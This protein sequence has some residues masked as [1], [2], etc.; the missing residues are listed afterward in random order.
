MCSPSTPP[1]RWTVRA[2][3]LWLGKS[4]GVA[5]SHVSRSKT[6][7]E[8]AIHHESTKQKPGE[9]AKSGKNYEKRTFLQTDLTGHR[10]AEGN[11]VEEAVPRCLSVESGGVGMRCSESFPDDLMFSTCK[12]WI[13][14]SLCWSILNY[15]DL[16]C[17]LIVLL[18]LLECPEN[19]VQCC[20]LQT[21]HA[22]QNVFLSKSLYCVFFVLSKDLFYRPL[23]SP[24]H[25][26]KVCTDLPSVTAASW[27]AWGQRQGHQLQQCHQ[28]MPGD[29]SKVPISIEKWREQRHCSKTGLRTRYCR[30]RSTIM[31]CLLQPVGFLFERMD[32]EGSKIERDCYFQAA[33]CN[34]TLRRVPAGLTP[35][36]C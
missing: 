29:S 9:L 26:P 36:S 18:C 25:W 14:V 10:L 28:R 34:T 20:H 13:I 27:A 11:A 30:S 2:W 22:S 35:C 16:F 15:C 7:K 12:W 17:M 24:T 23:D 1:L 4:S 33:K 19:M 32:F 21:S 8:D 5:S 6:A 3:Q 31:P